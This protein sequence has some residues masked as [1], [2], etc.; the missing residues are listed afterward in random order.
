MNEEVIIV[1][2]LEGMDEGD[3]DVYDMD[4]K[5]VLTQY[6]VEWVS[7]RK[8]FQEIKKKLYEVQN[9]LTQLDHELERGKITE[10]EHMGKYQEKWLASTQMVQVKREVEARLYEIQSEIRQANKM[11]REQEVERFRREQIEQEK[12]NAM[13][14]WMSLKQGFDVVGQRRREITSEMDSVE[15]KRRSATISDAD[16]RKARLDQIRQ[17]AEL[18]TLE[19]DIK[20][21]LSEL[22]DIIRK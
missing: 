13:I 22:I 19:T 6:A 1:S 20:K 16:Y 8:S 5:E 2:H 10:Q 14:E 21:R 11:L 12:S 7:L 3:D 18:R 15:I 4:L 17:L 9:E